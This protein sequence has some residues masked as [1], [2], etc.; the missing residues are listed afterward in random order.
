MASATASPTQRITPE[1][2]FSDNPRQYEAWRK[3]CDHRFVLYGGAAG[4]G[5]S[6]F[7]RWWAVFY[8]MALARQ[9]VKGATVGLFCEDYPSLLDRQISKIR[10]EFPSSLGELK[11][12]TT[13]DFQLSS[14]YGSGRILL[15]NLDDPAKYLSA[16]FAGIAVDEL[17]RN[18]RA[19]F[20]FLRSRLRWPGVSRPR[21]VA[22]T[23]PSGRGHAWVKKLWKDREFPPELEKLA[24]EFAFVPAKSS[25]NPFLDEQYH[26]DLE[27][28]PPAMAKA[29]AEGSWDIFAGQY[30]DIWKESLVVRPEDLRMQSWNTRWI[31]IDWGYKHPSAVY[32]HC[33]NDDGHTC[34]Y[35]EFVRSRLDA[36]ELGRQIIART[37]ETAERERI[38]DVYL[39]PDA[40]AQRDSSRTTAELLGDELA[41]GGLPQPVAA[42]D[43]RVGGW[44]LM[45]Q[46]LKSGEWKVSTSCR[47]LIR[48][49]PT[50][51]YGDTDVEDCAKI[52]EPLADSGV[53]VDEKNCS[54]DDPPDSARYGLKSRHRKTAK[55]LD[56]RVKER[57]ANF[58]E[59]RNTTIENLMP[60]TIGMLS[61]KAEILERRFGRRG[62][63][64]RLWHPGRPGRS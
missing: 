62:H 9:G 1:L 19:V 32:W 26:A 58:A 4:G 61:R 24:G 49:L 28:L 47:G 34:T 14:L 52:D 54:G 42:D 12:G 45:Y 36:D 44:R 10:V 55:P 23:N 27:T 31:S 11:E 60:Q 43:D 40:W 16:E 6:Y 8:L 57:I 29:Y 38:A 50:L 59:K 5:K 48:C 39:S 2:R 17:T 3:A 51:I 46:M 20:D 35:R 53:I 22:G 18:D 21:F 25:D 56:I 64:S 41:R 13:R 15:R 7:L 30:F 37:P 33:L 63:G